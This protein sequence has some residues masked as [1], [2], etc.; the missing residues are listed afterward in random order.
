MKLQFLG[1]SR[2]AFKWDLLHYVVTST[3]PGFSELTFVP[4]LTP[5]VPNLGHGSTP[6]SRYP[7]RPAILNFVRSLAVA[8]R[9]L[10]RVASIGSLPGMAS[11]DDHIHHPNQLV[12][13]GW[14]RHSYWQP[15]VQRPRAESLVF[16]DP[17]NGFETDGQAGQQHLRFGEAA[18]LLSVLPESSSLAVFQYRPQ[19]QS[20]DKVFKRIAESFPVAFR[21]VA[22]HDG[23][24]AFVFIGHPS[25]LKAIASA[26]NGY[27][28]TQRT[29]KIHAGN[30]V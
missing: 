7:C 3:C 15:L 11:F 24:L 18:T 10:E 1:D 29:L 17:D 19:G 13:F 8:P 9:T 14:Q 30:S 26:V 5:D 12:G 28:A 23:Q 25:R 27:A 6:P 21:F 2:D 16:I 20:W 22:I 4:M